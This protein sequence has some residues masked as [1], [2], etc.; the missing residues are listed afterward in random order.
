MPINWK[1]RVFVCVSLSLYYSDLV[2]DIYYLFTPIPTHA[3]T[4]ILIFLL[5]QPSFYLLYY[6]IALILPVLC[7]DDSKTLFSFTV[8]LLCRAPLYTLLCEF[9]LMLSP[10]YS[11]VS[12]EESTIDRM[13]QGF[14]PY[15]L[16]HS[17][18]QSLPMLIYQFILLSYLHPKSFISVLSPCISTLTFLYSLLIINLLKQMNSGGL[19]WIQKPQPT[20]Q[21]YALK[22]NNLID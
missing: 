15:L 13:K 14:L 5:I 6:L 3:F 19:A 9:K 20:L 11:L 8:S 21:F 4:I 12:Q 2:S 7:K 17:L 16:I 1:R 18:F 22:S 10:L